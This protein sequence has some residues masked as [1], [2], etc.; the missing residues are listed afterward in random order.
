[1]YGGAMCYLYLVGRENTKRNAMNEKKIAELTIQLN[2][3]K[4]MMN[5][6]FHL[7]ADAM[8]LGEH[9]I[10]CNFSDKM[11]IHAFKANQIIKQIEDL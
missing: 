5:T 11:N 9:G 3:E 7:S 4:D 6:Y 10:A 1:M 8:D 2:N